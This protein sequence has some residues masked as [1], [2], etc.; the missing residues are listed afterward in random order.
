MGVVVLQSNRAAF[1]TRAHQKKGMGKKRGIQA[2]L[3]DY[4]HETMGE[5]KFLV[6]Q[7]HQDWHTRLC[8]GRTK[9]W[10]RLKLEKPQLVK[11][12]TKSGMYEL[13]DLGGGNGCGVQYRVHR[14]M[15]TD[16]QFRDAVQQGKHINACDQQ[17]L[18]ELATSTRYLVLDRSRPKQGE[19]ERQQFWV[20]VFVNI[21]NGQRERKKFV[22]PFHTKTLSQV[23]VVSG[24]LNKLHKEDRT[25]VFVDQSWD[26][27]HDDWIA[28]VRL[29]Q[30]CGLNHHHFRSHSFGLKKNNKQVEAE[31]CISMVKQYI[32]R[33]ADPHARQ[34]LTSP[35]KNMPYITWS[36]ELQENLQRHLQQSQLQEG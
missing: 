2:Y 9:T 5:V 31:R 10:N 13:L 8:A 36:Q 18:G 1:A 22:L 7:C 16:Q 15:V 32:R 14:D 11:Y 12:I 4:P 29:V 25:D 26:F 24:L 19:T 21:Q 28:S 20:A 6:Q 35:P 27:K 30:N 34:R 17:Q 23:L 33:I 3:A